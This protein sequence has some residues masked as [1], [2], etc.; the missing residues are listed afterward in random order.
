MSAVAGA[1]DLPMELFSKRNEGVYVPNFQTDSVIILHEL[2]LM[3]WHFINATAAYHM[4]WYKPSSPVGCCAIHKFIKYL[5]L[6]HLTSKHWPE[7]RVQL[8]TPMFIDRIFVCLR[9]WREAMISCQKYFLFYYLW[10]ESRAT[11][12]QWGAK[13]RDRL[14]HAEATISMTLMRKMINVTCRWK[15]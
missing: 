4:G 9:S 13:H 5:S 14:S 15:S 11:E 2:S 6:Q 7:D 12:A 1:V 10:M 3:F 8:V